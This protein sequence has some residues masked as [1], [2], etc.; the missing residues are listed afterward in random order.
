MVGIVDVVDRVKA[1][2]EMYL[3]HSQVVDWSMHE[4]TISK[5]KPYEIHAGTYDEYVRNMI[6]R[7]GT[8]MVFCHCRYQPRH[9]LTCTRMCS[10]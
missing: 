6:A 2:F 10:R 3:V 7:D 4:L 5:Q 1:L 8:T 9:V